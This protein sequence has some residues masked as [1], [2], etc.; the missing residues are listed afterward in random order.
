[1]AQ[2][3]SLQQ[4]SLTYMQTLKGEYLPCVHSL[5]DISNDI[6]YVSVPVEGKTYFYRLVPVESAQLGTERKRPRE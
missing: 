5:E 2:R 1:M 4:T 6:K 3:G